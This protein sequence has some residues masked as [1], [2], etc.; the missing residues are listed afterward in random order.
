MSS[1]GGEG[2]EEDPASRYED[3]AGVSDT[4]RNTK[5]EIKNSLLGED[6]SEN[7]IE[8]RF[9]DATD[10]DKEHTDLLT[11]T[12]SAFGPNSEIFDEIG[13]RVLCAEPLWELDSSLSVPDA[14]IG[15][16]DR[17]VVISVECKTG[18]SNPQNTLE[19]IRKQA[20]TLIDNQAYLAKKTTVD[21]ED[22]ERVLCVPGRLSDRARDAIDTEI[23]ESSGEEDL[24][25]I[26]LWKYHMFQQ[27]NLQLHTDFKNRNK[28]E[29]THSSRV[30]EYLGGEGVDVA[31]CPLL[32]GSFYPGTLIYNIIEKVV[33]DVL[34]ERK[35]EGLDT[36]R[37]TRAEVKQEVN[38]PR[39]VPHYET[40][41]V[42]ESITDNI[43]SDFL[44]YNIVERINPAEEGY[45]RG[46]ELF[47]IKAKIAGKRPATVR[48][49]IQRGY[50]ER[51]IALKAEEEARR[52]AIEQFEE[53]HVEIGD[54]TN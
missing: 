18:L 40:E 53:T 7:T 30:S 8:A 26:F 52:M 42:A 47:E 10:T 12:I 11:S 48:D 41:P 49:N 5:N 4:I 34:H 36:R 27:E 19:Q 50:K 54:F 23:E 2:E 38:D 16:P 45:G 28:S 6:G 35:Q 25:P 15:H 13:W 29:S 22:V 9:N 31:S 44:K 17:E 14:L 51:W 24:P 20:T 32:S 39:N 21:F 1:E 43:I 33:F 3:L 46:M 37:F